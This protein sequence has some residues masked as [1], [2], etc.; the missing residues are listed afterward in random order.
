L[1]EE[2]VRAAVVNVAMVRVLSVAFA[3]VLANSSYSG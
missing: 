3:G 2:M 1:Y